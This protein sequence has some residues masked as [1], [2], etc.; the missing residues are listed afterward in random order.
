MSKLQT[1]RNAN[2][3]EKNGTHIVV[4]GFSK[5]LIISALYT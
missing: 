2:E 5:I 3:Q 4:V 1:S